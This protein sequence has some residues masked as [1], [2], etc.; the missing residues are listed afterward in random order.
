MKF[1]VKKSK[2]ISTLSSMESYKKVFSP[3][4]FDG[5]DVLRKRDFTRKPGSMGRVE[6][7]SKRA[8]QLWLLHI[9]PILLL[10]LIIKS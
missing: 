5:K 6:F 3:G 10:F 4:Q 9:A 2:I 8:G 7:S 1:K